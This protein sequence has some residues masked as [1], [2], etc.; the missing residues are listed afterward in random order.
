MAALVAD[1]TNAVLQRLAFEARQNCPISQ[2]VK[3]DVEL[4]TGL[5]EAAL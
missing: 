1:A 3:I 4:T 5:Q 2:L